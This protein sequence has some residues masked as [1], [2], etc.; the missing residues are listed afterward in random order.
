MGLK[1]QG[2]NGKMEDSKNHLS[3]ILMLRSFQK[4]QKLTR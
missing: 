3:L 1:D 2:E 4:L